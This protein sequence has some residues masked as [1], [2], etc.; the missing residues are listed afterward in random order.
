MTDAQR[1]A[2]EKAAARELELAMEDL[3]RAQSGD[4]SKRPKRAAVTSDTLETLRDRV[5]QVR[6]SILELKKAKYEFG[7]TF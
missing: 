3:A 6:D 2:A 4:F 1:I 7:M 5:R